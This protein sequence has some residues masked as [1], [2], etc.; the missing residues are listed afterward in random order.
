MPKAKTRWGQM[1][2]A[3]AGT[4]T[5]LILSAS[6]AE[7]ADAFKMGVIDP[8]VVLEKSKAIPPISKVRRESLSFSAAKSSRSGFT[9]YASIASQASPDM[10]RVILS[11]AAK[12]IPA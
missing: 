11:A 7:A 4:G 6:G 9:S 2:V 5:W 12:T 1:M 10:P 3:L 8:Q